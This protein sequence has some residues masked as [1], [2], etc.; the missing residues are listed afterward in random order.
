MNYKNSKRR[1]ALLLVQFT[2]IVYTII[3]G[4]ETAKILGFLLLPLI[5][6]SFKTW[7]ES[8]DS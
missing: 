2:A 5:L 7:V 6:Y 1:L 8:E 3:S 4:D